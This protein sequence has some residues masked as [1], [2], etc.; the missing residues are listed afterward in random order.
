LRGGGQ[1]STISHSVALLR[2]SGAAIAI[3]V[4]IAGCSS[5][6]KA[7]P[8]ALA[9]ERTD[10]IAVCRALDAARPAAVSDVAA[11]RAA[12]PLIAGGIPTD[13]S[14]ISRPAI[15]LAVR[16]AGALRVPGLFEER[17]AAVLTGAGSSL[18]GIFRT[19]VLL[20]TRSWR[21]IGAAIEQVEHGSPAAARFA[22]ANVALYIESVYDAHFS[23]AQIG[24]K[25]LVVYKNQGGP[26]AFGT[27][28]TQAE[29]NRL[30]E[31]YSEARDR[32][33]PHAGVKLGS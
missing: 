14:T 11:T 6:T 33:Y 26:A 3:A 30:A 17:Q 13:A 23:L 10:L 4:A 32:L 31:T 29:V 20:A 8:Q 21:L 27:S 9:L 18:A 24:K 15:E 12:W 28:L 25:L 19:Y 1:S 5:S 22:R 16:R 7:T 2:S